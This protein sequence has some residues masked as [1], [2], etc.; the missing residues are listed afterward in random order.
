MAITSNFKN[1]KVVYN[2]ALQ[3]LGVD[4]SYANQS[5]EY[6][7]GKIMT[8]FLS[9]VSLDGVERIFPTDSSWPLNWE[10]IN[11]IT[12][13]YANKPIAKSLNSMNASYD[14]NTTTK[15]LTIKLTQTSNI[16]FQYN[17][18]DTTNYPYIGVAFFYGATDPL[19]VHDSAYLDIFGSGTLSSP[20]NLSAGNTFINLSG[21]T[22]LQLNVN[23]ATP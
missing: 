16:N 1:N 17:P 10:L 13:G 14:Y 2:L 20:I 9:T 23:L 19:N 6:W 4:R 21:T 12:Y 11:P 18:A 8:F 3:G 5:N 22:M 15:L 7:A